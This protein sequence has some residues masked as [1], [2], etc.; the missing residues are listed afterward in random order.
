VPIALALHR[1]THGASA[2]F[3]PCDPLHRDTPTSG[4]GAAGR[5]RPGQPAG[6][7]ARDFGQLARRAEPGLC[8]PSQ[9]LSCSRP[10]GGA[11]RRGSGGVGPAVDA[12]RGEDVE[13]G[14][15]PAVVVVS[16]EARNVERAAGAAGR[17][18]WWRAARRARRSL[19]R[20]RSSLG[21]LLAQDLHG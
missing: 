19:R 10:V 3:V 18:W 14:A 21:A 4:R 7:G 12:Q 9:A 15:G 8:Q 6:W 2:L 17:R 5:R 20:R 16:G 1:V 11:S 13:R